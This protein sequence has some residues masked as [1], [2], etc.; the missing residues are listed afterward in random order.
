MAT[1]EWSE[2]ADAATHTV[3]ISFPDGADET[4]EVC[5]AH[6]RELKRQAVHSRPK[7][8]PP[9]VAPPPPVEVQCGACL[10]PLDEAVS[11]PNHERQPCTACG[12]LRRL[13]KITIVE[14][15]A[16]HESL[17]M[18]SKQPGK[19]RWMTDIRT[20]DDYTRA[21]EAWGTRLLETD[22]VRNVYREV[23][24]LYDGT[25]VESRARLTDHHD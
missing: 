7:P 22:R 2:C 9:P 15:F 17:R 6:D 20:G 23:I 1:C 8:S 19:G 12:S 10:Q 11:I 21:L 5:R 13:H 16:A 18:R 24:T 25:R 4:W 14:A 3:D